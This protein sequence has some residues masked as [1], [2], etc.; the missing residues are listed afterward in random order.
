MAGSAGDNRIGRAFSGRK[1]TDSIAWAVFA[2]IILAAAILM[3]LTIRQMSANYHALS[4]AV[5]SLREQ[6]RQID[7]EFQ[8]LPDERA[9][10]PINADDAVPEPETWRDED[11]ALMTNPEWLERPSGSDLARYYPT[12]AYNLGIQGRAIIE[13]RVGV[14]GRLYECRIVEETPAR[15]GFG[16]ATLTVARH[17]RMRPQLRDGEPVEGAYVRFPINWR[18]G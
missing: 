15:M 18:L 6:V 4:Q 11:G 8:A 9:S 2:A 10:A 1:L 14:D 3:T 7:A 12:V 16:S 5:A 13:C 17:F